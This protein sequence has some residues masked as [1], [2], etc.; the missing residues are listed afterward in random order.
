MKQFHFEKKG[1]DT[2]NNENLKFQIE[3]K[4]SFFLMQFASPSQSFYQDFELYQR[5]EN[6]PTTTSLPD[7]TFISA[8]PTSHFGAYMQSFTPSNG[9]ASFDMSS[10]FGSF[11][12]FT[13]SL[14]SEGSIVMSND[15]LIET[16]I[17]RAIET[18]DT[19]QVNLY[20][21]RYNEYPQYLKK[22]KKRNRRKAKKQNKP[23][24]Q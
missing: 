3:L 23:N 11:N 4:I 9:D 13:G 8:F 6:P 2:K 15:S 5:T 14:D 21:Q 10:S 1:G 12:E 24:V 16:P 18:L 19:E 20:W 22:I 7:V 17:P